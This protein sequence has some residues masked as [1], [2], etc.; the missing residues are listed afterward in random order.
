MRDFE[1]DG[2]YPQAS[3]KV[4]IFWNS[5]TTEP[6]VLSMDT[7]TKELVKNSG[8]KACYYAK[9]NVNESLPEGPCFIRGGGLHLSWRLV[10]DIYDAF[11][12]PM[13]PCATD[14]DSYVYR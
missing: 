9:A 5:S 4:V 14:P 12:L 11:Q 6:P 7:D 3:L 10:D 1:D 2:E 8:C 13:L